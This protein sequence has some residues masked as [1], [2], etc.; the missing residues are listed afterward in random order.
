MGFVLSDEEKLD[1]LKTIVSWIEER[2]IVD[3]CFVLN[4]D[5]KAPLPWPQVIMSQ[6]FL[7]RTTLKVR[8]KLKRC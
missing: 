2:D 1:F 3:T 8:I 4:F 6:R 7:F 5:Y